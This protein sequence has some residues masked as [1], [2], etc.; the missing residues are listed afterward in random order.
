MPQLQ[1]YCD[2][3]IITV[4]IK[5]KKIKKSIPNGLD[6]RGK[7]KNMNCKS[8]NQEGDKWKEA[9]NITLNNFWRPDKFPMGISFQDH[10]SC[11]GW[12]ET[13]KCMIKFMPARCV[14]LNTMHTS[15]SRYFPRWWSCSIA[16]PEQDFMGLY[17]GFDLF[18]NKAFEWLLTKKLRSSLSW[19]RLLQKDEFHPKRRQ[20]N[21]K[22]SWKKENYKA[23]HSF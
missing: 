10:R 16:K 11:L 23:L 7:F 6:C 17:M 22:S 20:T 2:Y 18:W 4:F 9:I 12:S 14:R 8:S 1:K 15:R 13:E 3:L 5:G 21:Q 19:I